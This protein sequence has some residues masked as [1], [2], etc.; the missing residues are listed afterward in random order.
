MEEIKN[1]IKISKYAGMREDLVQ[2]GGGNTSVKI[3]DE[4]IYIKSSGYHLSEISESK[5]YSKVNYKKMIDIFNKKSSILYNDEKKIMEDILILG[6]KPSIETFLHSITAGKYTLHTHP[7]VVNI[8]TTRKGGMKTLKD[9]FPESLVIDYATP[10][11]HLA[12]KIYDEKLKEVKRNKY[13]IIF[14]KNHGLIV[15]GETV[16]EV[17]EKNE[18][19][20][21]ILEE[22]LKINMN[23][24]RNSSF[25]FDNLEKKLG[26]N[27]VY[28]CNNY[29]VRKYLKKNKIE[30]LKYNFSP[31]SIVYCGKKILKLYNDKN[32]LEEAEIHVRKY[33]EFNI[34]YY[35]N[36]LYIVALN[37]KKAKEI[38]SIL[39]FNIQILEFNKENEMEFLSGKEEDFLLN[40]DSEKYRKDL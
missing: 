32:I 34:I 35:E 3:D 37:V 1:L 19:I 20:L 12:K 24:H 8:L 11:I 38:E 29:K 40:W 33:G 28:L 13:D 15:S 31:D 22:K 26:E 23:S 5:G 17:I 25:L 36:E 16:I 4:V 6:E 27:I 7:V 21:R 30:D 18:E 39:D 14:L 2:A 9:I 10:G